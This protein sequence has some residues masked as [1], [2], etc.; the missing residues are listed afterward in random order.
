LRPLQGVQVPAVPGTGLAVISDH[1]ARADVD[2]HSA[3]TGNRTGNLFASRLYPIS[4]GHHPQIIATILGLVYLGQGYNHRGA[5]NMTGALFMM[6]AN[7]TMQNCFAVVNV[8]DH[9]LRWYL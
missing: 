4:P 5:R 6:V 3:R 9:R 1:H 2:L 8:S 7:L